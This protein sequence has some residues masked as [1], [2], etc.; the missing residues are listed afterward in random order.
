[1]MYLGYLV[2][3][4]IATTDDVIG[5]LLCIDRFIVI[6]A[7]ALVQSTSF[8][9]TVSGENKVRL[10]RSGRTVSCRN[11][12]S[13]MLFL[14]NFTSWVIDSS[15]KFEMYDETWFILTRYYSTIQYFT[16]FI[17]V[18]FQLQLKRLVLY[19]IVTCC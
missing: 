19:S 13:S 17:T 2:N 5:T 4:H 3:R 10:K 9:S 6:M 18:V 11:F 12:T 1:M 7:G 14:C 16:T 8:P 15:C